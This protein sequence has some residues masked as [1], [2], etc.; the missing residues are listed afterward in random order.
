LLDDRRFTYLEEKGDIIK[1]GKKTVI[2]ATMN[3]GAG[4]T[5]TSSIDF[6]LEDRFPRIIE[7]N[8]L[9]NSQEVELLSNRTGISK[10]DAK[11]LVDIATSVRKKNM[12]LDASFSKS[13]STRQL[14]SIAQDFVVGGV[15]TLEYTLTNHFNSEGGR[16]SERAAILQM[17]QGK[18]GN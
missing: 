8:Y 6:A 7:L 10:S 1:V 12:G 2:F 4:Y 9:L 16:E 17:I 5:G 3:E 18:W 13:I 14:I 11:K 15:P